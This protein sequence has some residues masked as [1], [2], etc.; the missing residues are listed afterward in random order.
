MSTG[1]FKPFSINVKGRLLRYERPAVMGIVNVTPDSFYAGSRTQ[2][3]ADVRRRVASLMEAGADMLDVGAYSTRPGSPEVT[4]AE[5]QRRLEVGLEALRREAP[6]VPVS[7]DTFRAAVA[8]EAVTSLGADIVN[9]V[10]G[11]DGDPDMLATVAALRC[12]YILM[13]MRG[14]PATMQSLTDYPRG[15]VA[16]VLEAMSRKVRQ[17]R[18]D[19]VNDVIADP[20][21][22]F[23]KTVEQNYELLDAIALMRDS[24]D[25]PVLA[26][27]SRKSMICRPLGITPAEALAPTTAVNTMAVLRGA[28][29]LRVHDALEAR[30]AL[31]LCGMLPSAGYSPLTDSN[32]TPTTH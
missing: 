17:L 13:H 12:P 1:I 16:E 21:F 29:I 8:R 24:L 15:V 30:Q 25:A 18:L 4:A 14:T 9:D 19:G 23:A 28:S 6:E 31:T 27:V 7:V 5:E 10:T 20:G 3:E 2:C 11:L 26:G 32:T 22:G